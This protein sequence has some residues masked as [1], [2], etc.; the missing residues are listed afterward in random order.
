MANSPSAIRASGRA[1]KE[2]G[3][4]RLRFKTSL[5]DGLMLAK[6]KRRAAVYRICNGPTSF[7]WLSDFT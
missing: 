7:G 5:E 2:R 4:D 1:E 6:Q 3:R